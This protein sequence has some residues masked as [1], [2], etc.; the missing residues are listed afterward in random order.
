MKKLFLILSFLLPFT[1]VAQ[2]VGEN[3]DVTHYEIHVG[4]FDLATEPCKEKP[5][6]TLRPQPRCSKSFSN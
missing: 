3:I 4:D 2:T 6:L 1:L 5:L